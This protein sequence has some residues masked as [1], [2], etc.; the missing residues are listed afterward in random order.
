MSKQATFVMKID[1]DLRD[2]FFAEAKVQDRP[3]AQIV[4]EMMR[5]YIE[6]RQSQRSYNDFLQRKVDAG[7]EQV[8]AGLLLD[9]KEV[10]TQ[11]AQWL[12][13]ASKPCA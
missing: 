3:A 5:S 10:E 12:E 13:Q 6:T 8:H 7:L 2:A 4:R 1:H 9:N 11:A